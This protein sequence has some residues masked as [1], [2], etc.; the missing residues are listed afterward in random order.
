MLKI[1]FGYKKSCLWSRKKCQFV[2]KSL[3]DSKLLRGTVVWLRIYSNVCLYMPV[4]IKCEYKYICD[5]IYMQ[6]IAR[7]IL[8]ESCSTIYARLS[9]IHSC[10]MLLGYIIFALFF[11]LCAVDITVNSDGDSDVAAAAPAAVAFPLSL[12]SYPHSL[13]F[14]RTL[15]LRLACCRLYLPFVC[16][17]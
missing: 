1:I 11:F 17:F 10:P 9:L 16:T 15:V 12:L 2:W 8:Q 4:L 7:G 13:I 3:G 5:Q 6:N 14:L